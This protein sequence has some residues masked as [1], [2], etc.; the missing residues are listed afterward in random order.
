MVRHTLKILQQMLEDFYSVSDHFK[1]LQSKRLTKPNR[2]QT[3]KY[4]P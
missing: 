1:T 2:L 3:E 4:S